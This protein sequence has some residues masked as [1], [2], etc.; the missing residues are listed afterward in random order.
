MQEEYPHQLFIK[1]F[2][3]FRSD[4]NFVL[5]LNAQTFIDTPYFPIETK[6]FSYDSPFYIC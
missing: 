6:H 5:D 4:N 2:I 1:G 3:K